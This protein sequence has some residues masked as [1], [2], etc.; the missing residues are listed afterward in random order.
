LRQLVKTHGTQS[1]LAKRIGRAADYIS[2]LLTKGKHRKRLEENL[3]REIEKS[4]GLPPLW[5]DQ[6]DNASIE[7][8]P[9]SWPF[10]FPRARFDQLS[11]R[12]REK[13]EAAVEI[14]VSLCEVDRGERTTKRRAA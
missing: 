2:R 8:G 14:M 11:P 5:L 13:I 1:A 7:P 12:D 9:G 6:A 4:L 10:S 3:A